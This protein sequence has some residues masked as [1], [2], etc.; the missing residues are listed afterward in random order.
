MHTVNFLHRE[1]RPN[2]RRGHGRRRRL[3]FALIALGVIAA[4]WALVVLFAAGQVVAAALDGRDALLRA[5]EHAEA[6]DF[7]RAGDDLADANDRFS[8]AERGFVLLRGARFIPW[9]SA[10]VGAAESLLTSGR[11][12]I[13][14]LESVVELG[15]ELVRLTGFSEEEIRAMGDGLAPSATF[16]DLPSE[17]KRAILERLASSAEDL[18]LLS[19]RIAIARSDL[20]KLDR[21][22]LVDPVAEALAPIDARLAEAEEMVRVLSIGAELLPEFAGLGRERAHLVLFLNNT[23][24]RPGGGFIGAFGVLKTLNGDVT[25]LETRDSYAL[26]NP[27]APFVTELAPSPLRRYNAADK[28][29]FRDAN[30]SPDFGE[31]ASAA[32]RLYHQEMASLTPE[33]R[34]AAGL[35]TGSFDGVIGLTPTFVQSLLRVTGPLTVGGQ[36]F[37]ADNVT[38]K[39]E[40]QVEVG[41]AGQG[42]PEAQR[43][44]VLADL[45]NAMKAELFA[46]PLS[47]WPRVIGAV[48]RAFLEKQLVLM[49]ADADTQEMIGKAG[50]GGRVQ[51]GAVDTQMLVDANLASLK[52]DPKVAR[53]LTYELY[54]NT[55]GQYVGRTTVRYAHTGTFDWKTT[56]YRTYARLYVPAG[57]ELIR[58]EGSMLNDRLHN[59]S[60]AAAPVDVENAFGLTS[61]GTFVSV[62]PGETRALVFEYALA[63]SVVAAIQAGTYELAVLRQVG[64]P[65]VALTLGLDF[66]KNVT[67]A[68]V[69]E[70]RGEWGDDAYRL[71]TAIDQN[72]LFTV[73][74]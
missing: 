74:L 40:Y 57:S 53:A 16:D 2:E 60:G 23:E 15:A 27:A 55:S 50:W 46:L 3:R 22:A 12:V 8:K 29:F 63:D 19:A 24:L 39:I 31:S 14:A 28:W 61:F 6:L 58:V 67:A 30:W 33:M 68:T 25:E 51:A 73:G 34:A 64:A 66:D 11:E 26:D 56:R 62:E 35:E 1:E 49:S 72:L 59:P 45:V 43:K 20:G 32:V 9:V 42:V 17:T 69:P 48:D 7:D 10:Q 54:R 36:T 18:R 47:E 44:E 4:A 13:V 37:D 21:D 52:T 5:R 38:D 41:Y 70:D 71:T 65:S